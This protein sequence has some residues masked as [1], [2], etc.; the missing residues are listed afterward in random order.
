MLKVTLRDSTAEHLEGSQLTGAEGP[1]K[2]SGGGREESLQIPEACLSRPGV[3][4]PGLGP[5]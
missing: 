4:G 3:H 5:G 1:P 2:A